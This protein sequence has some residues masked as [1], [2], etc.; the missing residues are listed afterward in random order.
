M[1]LDYPT[2]SELVDTARASLRRNIPSIDPTVENQFAKTL[3]DSCAALAHS[4]NLQIRDLEKQL[5]PQTSEGD[6]LDLWLEYEGLTRNA[7]TGGRG[8][9]T[10]TGTATTNVPVATSF[11][12]TNGFT[13]ETQAVATI[14]ATNLSITSIT[15]SGTTATVTL[16]DDHGLASGNTP[17]ISGANESEY[18]GEQEITVLSSTTFTYEV[19]GSPSTPATGTIE[20]DYDYASVVVECT[21]TGQD[22]NISAGGVL[23]IDTSISG[24]DDTAIVGAEG[25]VGGADLETDADAR[26][27]LLLSRA[28]R[29][30]VFTADQIRLAALTI[31]GNTRVFVISPELPYV[32]GRP[33]AGQVYIYFLRDDDVDPLPTP[34]LI[35]ETKTAIIED[36][37]LPANTV[38]DDVVVDAPTAVITDFTFS[39]ISPD[40]ATMQTAIEEQLEAFYRDS[41]QL[42]TDIN[43][44]SYV[45]AIANTID[46]N[47]GERL[48]SFTLSAPSGDITIDFG[49]IGF[50]GTVTFP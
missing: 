14:T 18:N 24:L 16:D 40:T 26:T 47:T 13:Y 7:A 25:L 15:R 1:P 28:S 6:F 46:T 48:D 4:N 36:G 19:S 30:G 10:L 27:R 29:P 41:I 35:A 44:T 23:T 9:V 2:Y 33:E 17:V 32:A 50:L 31:S 8:A 5:F 38:E 20:L 22:T 34:T 39:S 21:T 45:A 42:S 12:A 37:K 3:V 49:E 43:E 11:T